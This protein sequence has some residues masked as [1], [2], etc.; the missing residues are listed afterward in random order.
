VHEALA[1][2]KAARSGLLVHSA[3]T[4]FSAAEQEV[5]SKPPRVHVVQGMHVER[6]V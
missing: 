6:E 4:R 3:H 2:R 1:V 5:D